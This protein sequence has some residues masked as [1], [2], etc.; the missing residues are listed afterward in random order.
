MHPL[1][2][3]RLTSVAALALLTSLI[4]APAAQAQ[5][6]PKATTAPAPAAATAPAPAAAGSA[7]AEAADPAADKAVTDL[8]TAAQLASAGWLTLLDQRNWGT[9]WDGA[10]QTFRSAVP[11]SN[12]MDGIPKVRAPFGAF[13]ERTPINVVYNPDNG[14]ATSSFRSK[15]ANKSDLEETVTTIK[16]ADGKWRVTG[17]STR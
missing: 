4:A 14:M 5:T 8:A 17:Y 6:K 3:Q 2:P 16:E 15:F 13:M 7:P 11:L 12:W 10:S 9:A 1:N